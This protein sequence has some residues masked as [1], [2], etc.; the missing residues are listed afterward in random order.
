LQYRIATLERLGFGRHPPAILREILDFRD[1][2][3]Q[4]YLELLDAPLDFGFGFG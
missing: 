1:T 2:P 3:P 4:F